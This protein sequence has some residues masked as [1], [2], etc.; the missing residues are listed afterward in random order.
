MRAS[1]LSLLCL[2]VLWTAATATAQPPSKA[3]FTRVHNKV[4]VL[5]PAKSAQPASVGQNIAAPAAVETGQDSRSELE[6]EDKSLL[7]LGSN[8]RF[9]FSRRKQGLQLTRGTALIKGK[10]GSETRVQAGGISAA[11]RG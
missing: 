10:P 8:S 7:R 5:Q 9:S 3:R 6:F 1:I 2:G 4:S 11:I